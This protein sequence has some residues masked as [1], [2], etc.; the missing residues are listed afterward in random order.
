M[1]AFAPMAALP[2]LGR[3]LIG[4]APVRQMNPRSEPGLAAIFS[5]WTHQLPKLAQCMEKPALLAIGCAI[6]T[7][8]ESA[9]PRR[10]DKTEFISASGGKN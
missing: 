8:R 4:S 3:K 7:T 1:S 5:E 10:K 6:A 2:S 9:A